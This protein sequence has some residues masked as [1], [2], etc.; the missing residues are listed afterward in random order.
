MSLREQACSG[1]SEA[2]CFFGNFSDVTAVRGSLNKRGYHYKNAF[3]CR[4]FN[5]CCN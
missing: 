3:K 1:V 4:L 2:P 5:T